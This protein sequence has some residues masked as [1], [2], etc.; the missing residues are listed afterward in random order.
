MGFEVGAA[1]MLNLPVFV[2]EP[3]NHPVDFPV[4]GVTHY[5]QRS[6]ESDGIGTTFW[7]SVATGSFDAK[8]PDHWDASNE[9]WW[10]KAAA[11]F[12]NLGQKYTSLNGRFERFTC[13]NDDCQ[14]PY[15][16]ESGLSS[17]AFPCPACRKGVA[18]PF[19]ELRLSADKMMDQQRA[20][21]QGYPR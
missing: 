17:K 7:A 16:I 11:F 18:T 5:A 6:A 14:S 19:T 13:P 1:A 21:Q 12:Y 4:P 8:D 9:D 15:F 20:A 10:T 2:I 3:S